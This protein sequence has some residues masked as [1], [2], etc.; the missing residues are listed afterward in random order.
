MPPSKHY[1][2]RQHTATH[3]HTLQRN[4]DALQHTSRYREKHRSTVPPSI[5][6]NTLHYTATHC[7]THQD[8]GR[9]IGVLCLLQHT[10]TCCITLQHTATHCNIHQDT[11]RN[12]GVSCLLVNGVIDKQRLQSCESVCF[13]VLQ[14]VAVC[15]SVLQCVAVCCNYRHG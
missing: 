9:N 14:Y 6:C 2:K 3:Y 10:S 5:H 13:S 1:N 4:S 7:I 11:G 12:I 15:C 8:T